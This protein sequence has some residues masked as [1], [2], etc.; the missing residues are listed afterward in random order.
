MQEELQKK[1]SHCEFVQFCFVWFGRDLNQSPGSC[2]LVSPGTTA[3]VPHEDGTFS[4]TYFRIQRNASNMETK[5]VPSHSTAILFLHHL[6]APALFCQGV[7]KGNCAET[8]DC[9]CHLNFHYPVQTHSSDPI[10][11]TL[12]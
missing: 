10:Q 1:A 11:Y 8:C 6:R 4:K 9:Y 7:L 5:I 3:R 12:M 2:Y